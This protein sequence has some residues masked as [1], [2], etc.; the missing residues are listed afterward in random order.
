VCSGQLSLLP[1]AGRE[2]SS[3]LRVTGWR[4]SVADWGGGISVV[5]HHWSNCPLSRA[6]DGCIMR[7]SCQSA[8]T[9]EIVK[10]CCSSL[11]KQRYSKYSDLY[12]YLYYCIRNARVF[13]HYIW[14]HIHW[15]CTASTASST[16]NGHHSM[17]AVRKNI[18]IGISV[19][20]FDV[21]SCAKL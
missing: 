8:A 19:M 16:V 6:M 9:S 18:S 14:R 3:S 4:P 10:C 2:M 17:F 15:L 11:C 20:S 13:T 7:R 21:S 5:L 1:S 12:L